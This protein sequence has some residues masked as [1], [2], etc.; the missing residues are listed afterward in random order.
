MIVPSRIQARYDD[1]TVVVK[2]MGKIIDETILNYCSVH[3]YAFVSRPKTVASLAEKLESGRIARWSEI[4]DLYACT[5]VVPILTLER[6]VLEFL[7][8]AFHQVALRLRGTTRKAPEV[9][10]FDS[11]RFLGRLRPPEPS[12]ATEP[13]YNLTFEVQIRSAFEHAW[14]VTTHELVYK[15]STIDWKRYRVAAQLKASVEQLDSV[16]LSFEA[17]AQSITEHEWPELRAKI[18]LAWLFVDL[19]ERQHLAAELAP[20][21][22]SRFSDNLYGLLRVS[23]RGNPTAFDGFLLK[24][25]GDLKAEFEALTPTTCPRSL[26]LLQLVFGTLTKLKFVKAPLPTYHALITPE[27]TSLF[28]EVAQFAAPFEFS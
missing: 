25:V 10:R 9:F 22:W 4:D 24:A 20:K 2:T 27:L 6:D 16:V 1:L 5:I 3:G 28:P 26:S 19:F 12:Y 7:R 18:G 23:Y 21:D 15:T 13:V 8:T 11:T 14:S 17:S